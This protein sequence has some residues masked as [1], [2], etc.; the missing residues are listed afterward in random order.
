MLLKYGKFYLFLASKSDENKLTNSYQIRIQQR[1]HWKEN[2]FV[3]NILVS[4][5]NHVSI[6]K[7][8]T[9]AIQYS[10]NEDFFYM[11]TNTKIEIDM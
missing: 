2:H 11:K 6:V 10:V 9:F 3:H 8:H 7:L 5:S 1:C 4:F